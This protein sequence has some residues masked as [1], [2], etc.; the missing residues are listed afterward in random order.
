MRPVVIDLDW[1]EEEIAKAN[2]EFRDAKRPWAKDRAIN[3]EV[4]LR[5]VEQSIVSIE[6]IVDY[7]FTAGVAAKT[8]HSK[9]EGGTITTDY[10]SISNELKRHKQKYNI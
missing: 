7:T 5:R 6:E 10:N 2:L 1:L 8:A 4:T 9:V 3:K